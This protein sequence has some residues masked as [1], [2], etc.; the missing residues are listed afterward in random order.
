MT[1]NSAFRSSPWEELLFL[2][3]SFNL[4]DRL[5][6]RTVRR[7]RYRGTSQ[8]ALRSASVSLECTG[9]D[10]TASRVVLQAMF[11]SVGRISV[12]SLEGNSCRKRWLQRVAC[13]ANVHKGQ[14]LRT[15]YMELLWCDLEL[16]ANQGVI[17][18]A[19]CEVHAVARLEA[20]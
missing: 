16:A 11:A 14:G 13:R 1:L 20:A 5:A 6:A 3:I 15:S 4:A 9:L 8:P 12:S 18:S 2:A 10:M 17:G 19:V 7:W